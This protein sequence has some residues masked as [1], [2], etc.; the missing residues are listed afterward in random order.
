MKS[1]L[2]AYVTPV[3]NSQKE[4]KGAPLVCVPVACLQRYLAGCQG[5]LSAGRCGAVKLQ[6]VVVSCTCFS[7]ANFVSF[8]SIQLC[9]P[10]VYATLQT[11]C[12]RRYRNLIRS[13]S[14]TTEVHLCFEQIH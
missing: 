7:T 3:W 2:Q 11:G 14:Q 10:V 1:G 5:R 6:L 8:P 12:G 9:I 4:T 13:E